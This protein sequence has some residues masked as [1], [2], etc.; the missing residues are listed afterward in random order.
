MHF[1]GG[2]GGQKMEKSNFILYRNVCM[3]ILPKFESGK[4]NNN[5][6]RNTILVA[7][8]A[9]AYRLHCRNDTKSKMADEVWKGMI[10]Q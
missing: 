3:S 7:P 1:L 6:H 2:G 4:N 8:G 10:G 5:I 9:V